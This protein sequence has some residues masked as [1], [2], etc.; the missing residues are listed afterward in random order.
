MI[1]TSQILCHKIYAFL[2]LYI[3]RQIDFSHAISQ[4]IGTKTMEILYYNRTKF[5]NKNGIE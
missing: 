2:V 1:V 4:I 3:D 5:Q